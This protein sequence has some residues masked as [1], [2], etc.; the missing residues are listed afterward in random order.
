MA[1]FDY[2]VI[3]S[4]A[5]G[6]PLAANLARA[7]FTVALL[8]A[9]GDPCLECEMGRWMY[10]VPIFHGLSTEYSECQWDYFV[11]HYADIAF[12]R[13][14]TKFVA[15]DPVNSQP[16]DGVWYPRAGALG[17]CTAH[18]AMITVTPQDR[19]WNGIAD[20]TGDASW[21]AENMNPYF[22]RL[23]DCHYTPRPG[24]A[25]YILE[26]LL[27][28]FAA[29]LRFRKDWRDWAHGHGFS[30]WLTTGE[31]DPLL[32]LK[33]REIVAALLDAAKVAFESGIENPLVSL[34]TKLDPN[35]IRNDLDMRE[36]LALT[37]L[38][39]SAGRRN[40]PRDY[41][42]R[43]VREYPRNLTVKLHALA[44]RIRFDGARRAV[45]V[46]FLEGPHL[47]EA[48]PHARGEK[49]PWPCRERSVSAGREIV[50]AGGAF[51]SPQLLKLSGIGP[52]EELRRF[53]IPEVA[54]LPGVG[55][56]LQDRY[57][58][59]VIS[60]FPKPFLLLEGATFEP[61]EPGGKPDPCFEEWQ[62]GKGIYATNGALVGI[63]KRSSRSQ[64]EPDLYIFGVPGYFKGY[65][66][67]YSAQFE[68]TRNRF[69]WAVLKAYTENRAGRVTLRSTD[70]R[71]RPDI[72][73]H[74]FGEGSDR[75]GADLD[76]VVNGVEFVRRMNRSLKADREIWPGDDC[77]GESLRQFIQREAW[78]HHASC[79][80][81][82]GR[83]N[84][85][86]AVLDSRFR[87]RGVSG[88]RV[89]D[90]SIFPRIPGY[91]IVSAIYMASEKASDAIL[92]DA[93]RR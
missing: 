23:E 71:Q 64:P 77:S 57:E 55:E 14:D 45:A 3:G 60:E 41:L 73:F 49:A 68:R 87:V 2:V 31:A 76:A 22:A 36:G 61:P 33:D 90:A 69:T 44:S 53:R 75:Q 62:R 74:Y 12:Q 6:G 92:E 7:G 56:N 66:P 47:Y 52:R 63:L 18:N 54:D 24:S 1:D 86:G 13:Q 43:T 11:R 93:G 40:G 88:L 17:G 81:R 5:G 19:D 83:E 84:D 29:L 35:D 85:P 67:G 72:D 9:G 28:S 37:P 15:N 51:N 70:P 42:L 46:D 79:T 8:E 59:G 38:A 65:F 39:V 4:G 16:V 32:A 58:V 10:D 20:L 89:V 21:R 48:D 78:G 27:W 80:N 26:G 82:M 50:L 91:F 30:G 34:L 25:N